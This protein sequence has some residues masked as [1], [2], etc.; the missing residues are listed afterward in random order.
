MQQTAPKV[1][2]CDAQ[3]QGLQE[4]FER[5]IFAVGIIP[6]QEDESAEKLPIERARCMTKVLK[7][8]CAWVAF[9]SSLN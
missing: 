6:S 5:C 3:D 4:N 2:G 1:A 7:S 9:S 8:A